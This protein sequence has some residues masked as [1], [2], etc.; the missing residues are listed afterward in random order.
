MNTRTRI[1][2]LV[3][4][5]ALLASTSA[6]AEEL[7]CTGLVG[8]VA[9]DNIFVPDGA[10]CQL[11]RTRLN[12]SLVVGRGATLRATSVSINGNLQA[13]GAASV[14]VGGFST[15]GGSVQLVQGGTASIARA[16]INGDLQFESNTGALVANGNVIGGSLQAFKN[17]GGAT[18][19]NNRMNGNMQCKE[20]IPAPTG[21]GNQSPSKEDQCS[22][23]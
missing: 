8:A 12:G 22:R 6:Y 4:S 5:V 11:D 9:V 16:R 13:E 2:R 21:S 10:F 18:F 17:W 14:Q 15:I 20:N 7:R 1:V 23:L 19:N 3:A